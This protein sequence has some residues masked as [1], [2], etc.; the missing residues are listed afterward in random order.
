M[1]LIL[2]DGTVFAGKNFGADVRAEGEVV[3]TTGMVGYVESLSDPSYAGQ[4]LVFTTP[5]VGNYGVPDREFFESG[6]VQ[7]AGVI[8]SEY[9]ENYSHHT[10]ERSLS[11]WLTEAGIPAITGIDTR[12]LTKKLRTYGVMLGSIVHDK[13]MPKNQKPLNDPNDENLVARVSITRPQTYGNGPLKIIAV[14]CGIKENIIRKLTRPDTTVT[15]VPWDYDFTRE[16]YDGIVFGNGPGDPTACTPTIKHIRRIFTQESKKE[17]SRQRPMLGICLGTQLMALA[18]GAK[19]YKLK[20]G[21]R[22]QNQPCLLDNHQTPK[23]SSPRSA[24]TL[25]ILVSGGSLPQRCYITSQNHGFAVEEK[26]LPKDW[27]VWF[28]NANDGS[29]EGIRH[30][31]SPWQAVQFHP[32]ASP[33][34]TDTG[35]IFDDFLKMVREYKK[36]GK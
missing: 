9:S 35:W 19:T 18:A 32:E 36:N 6:R 31:T 4:I 27:S 22:S 34:P 20:F 25:K 21:H 1:K 28:T 14:D 29:V 15:R 16:T 10:A 33:G 24:Q 5:L 11:R 3:F 23:F 2:E 13:Q 7:A 17:R 8:V 30:K 12:A 26:S